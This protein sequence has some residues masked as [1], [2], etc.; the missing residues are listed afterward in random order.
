[1]TSLS[2]LKLRDSRKRKASGARTV[3]VS[4]NE[5]KVTD[6]LRIGPVKE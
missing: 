2:C 3:I 4:K 5:N 1:M 6:Y